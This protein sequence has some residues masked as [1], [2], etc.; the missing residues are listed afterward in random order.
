MSFQVPKQSNQ[1]QNAKTQNPKK[2]SKKEK[3]NTI[4]TRDQVT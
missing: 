4:K 1:S 2:Q 3:P